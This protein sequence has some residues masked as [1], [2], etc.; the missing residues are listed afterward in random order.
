MLILF[1]GKLAKIGNFSAYK[2]KLTR[3][4]IKIPF[5][6]P[7]DPGSWWPGRRARNNIQHIPN[8]SN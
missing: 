4:V 8:R 5:H 1:N 2:R 7:T 6:Q 3:L